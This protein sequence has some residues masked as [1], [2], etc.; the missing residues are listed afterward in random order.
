MKRLLHNDKWFARYAWV[1]LLLIILG[2]GFLAF[3]S[4]NGEKINPVITFTQGVDPLNFKTEKDVYNRGEMV[5][6]YT[7]FCKNREA[8]AGSLWTLVNEQI[9]FFSPKV[10]EKELPIGC[11]PENQTELTLVNIHIIPDDV[12]NGEHYFVGVG[13]QVLPN[14]KIIKTSYKTQ[15]FI[16][17]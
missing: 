12:V 5:R 6:I 16:V 3:N 8:T 15:K 14:G 13:T 11:Y 1:S 7:S 4:L 9:I 17:E 10:P 2:L